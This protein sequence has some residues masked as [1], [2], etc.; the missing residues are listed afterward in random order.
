VAVTYSP[1]QQSTVDPLLIITPGAKE[2]YKLLAVS[3][4]GQTTWSVPSAIQIQADPTTGIGTA[5]LNASFVLKTEFGSAPDN[6]PFSVQQVGNDSFPSWLQVSPTSGTTPTTITLTGNANGLTGIQSTQ[7]GLAA[8]LATTIINVYLVPNSAQASLTVTPQSL[9]FN[10]PAGATAT[11]S[12]Q[13]TVGSTGVPLP[14]AF[15]TPPTGITYTPDSGTTPATVTVTADPTQLPSG[16][17]NQFGHLSVPGTGTTAVFNLGTE[18]GS[19]SISVSQIFDSNPPNVAVGALVNISGA[20]DTNGQ[21]FTAVDFPWPTTLGGYRVSIN[22]V[23]LPLASVSPEAIETQMLFDLAPGPVSVAVEDPNGNVVT[24]IV[25][26]VASKLTAISNPVAAYKLDGSVVSPDNPVAPGDTVVLEFTGQGRLF[27]PVAPGS[28]P[29]AA[30]RS[31]LGQTISATIGGMPANIQSTSMSSTMPGVLVVQ[32]QVPDL[33]TDDYYAE[34]M[35][36]SGISP[37]MPVHV[38][39]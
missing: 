32:V 22:G 17:S 7:I 30:Q 28:V 37:V 11:Q 18:I 34:V 20:F 26:V 3:N 19:T 21:T 1:A 15:G 12:Q 4:G 27:P 24:S 39:K 29:V 35:L 6:V 2:S 13:I 14:F 33:H 38:Q 23:P 5:T 10:F 16:S 25:T 36:G 31:F 9:Q 8:G